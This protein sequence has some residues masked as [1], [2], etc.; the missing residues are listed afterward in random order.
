M[1]KTVKILLYIILSLILIDSLVRCAIFYYKVGLSYKLNRGYY[2]FKGNFWE[3]LKE[4]KEHRALIK[5]RKGEGV[6]R[7][8]DIFNR[9]FYKPNLRPKSIRSSFR[10]NSFGIRGKEIKLQKDAN[11]YRIICSG[12]SYT[13][14]G[15]EGNTFSDMLAKELNDKYKKKRFE[16]I[17]AG[18][19]SLTILQGFMNF[20]L[21]LRFLNPDMVIIDHAVDDIPANM[22]FYLENYEKLNKDNEIHDYF[23]KKIK[24]YISLYA[25]V[26]FMNSKLIFNSS[27]N[28][29]SGEGLAYY[30]AV[31]ESFVLLAKGMGAKVVLLSC[32]IAVDEDHNIEL[33]NPKRKWLELFYSGLPVN[34]VC[35]TIE[36]YNKIMQKVAMRNDV[37][38]IDMS[39]VVP[40]DDEHFHDANHRTDEGNKIFAGA[41]LDKLI[42]NNIFER[43]E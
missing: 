35:R 28:K 18:I 16:I 8:E 5:E 34:V 1:R 4:Y 2:N 43:F 13:L 22:P 32:G 41:L 19:P 21:N 15:D 37:I 23:I 30:E 12:S 20:A 25:F 36:E 11:T 6:R 10:T 29:P 26:D 33:G 3:Y 24:E 38:F 27:F 40:K 14:A 9:K 31:L 7:V 39:K 17:N 42:K